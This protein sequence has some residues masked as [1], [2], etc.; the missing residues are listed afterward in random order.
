MIQHNSPACSDFSVYIGIPYS[1]HGKRPGL[2]CW[3]LVEKVM[4]ECFGVRPPPYHFSGDYR[5]V[6]PI[7]CAELQAWDYVPFDERR[8]GDVIL[9]NMAGYPIHLGI[10]IDKNQMLHTLRE[11]GSCIEKI[12]GVKW[13]RR[14]SGVYR[15]NN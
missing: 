9:L 6:A 4:L 7:F 14:V 3:E 1:E 15:W 8:P 2:N 5:D 12:K 13:Q 11:T 10:L